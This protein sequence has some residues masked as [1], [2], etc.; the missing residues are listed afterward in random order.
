[1]SHMHVPARPQQHSLRLAKQSSYLQVLHMKIMAAHQGKVG[2]SNK[3]V[4][5]AG[6]DN[7]RQCQQQGQ[8]QMQELTA[9]ARVQSA[10]L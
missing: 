7:S 8:E 2:G 5:T 1:M 6:S 10:S 4:A 3:A 9:R